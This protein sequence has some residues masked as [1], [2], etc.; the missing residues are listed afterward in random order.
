MNHIRAERLAARDAIGLPYLPADLPHRG[1]SQSLIRRQ[2]NSAP[3][4][5]SDP[6]ADFL[7]QA[8]AA[9]S[10][11]LGR[12]SGKDA[13]DIDFQGRSIGRLP[14]KRLRNW[15][16][17]CRCECGWPGTVRSPN[18][19]AQLPGPFGKSRSMD[20]THRISSR[21]PRRSPGSSQTLR[22]LPEVVV[23]VVPDDA[24]RPVEPPPAQL[25]I[26]IEPSEKTVELVANSRV[27][28][29]LLLAK[30]AVE[31]EHVFARKSARTRKLSSARFLW[32]AAR[33]GRAGAIKRA[34]TGPFRLSV[35][36]RH[37][38]GASRTNARR[39]RDRVSRDEHDVSR[40]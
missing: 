7:T 12:L 2:L 19:S 3:F 30:I 14:R 22:G 32:C 20:P 29:T 4:R 37:V 26:L 25:A 6:S 21:G 11:Y 9:I 23:A 10:L 33:A 8:V 38:P 18:M 13:F 40:I 17:R 35:V 36:A 5:A 31:L 15:R 27:I 16:S 1:A 24:V 39:N 34:D 28:D